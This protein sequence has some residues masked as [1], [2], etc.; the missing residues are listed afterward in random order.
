M[1]AIP[2]VA[3]VVVNW[4]GLADT[5]ECLESVSRITYPDARVIVVDNGSR[6]D[7]AHALRAEF[8]GVEVLEAGANLGFTG[9]NNLGI[10]RALAEGAEYV[11]C[12][13]N[14]TVVDPGFLEPL[15]AA[16]EE[17]AG[18]GAAVSKI[19]TFDTPEQVWYA[20]ADCVLDLE[21]LRARGVPAWH[22]SDEQQNHGTEPF[23]T[24]VATGCAL[25]V[26]ASLMRDLGGFD[27]RYFAYY[28]DVD[29]SLRLEKRSSR[30]LVVPASR[31]WHKE[32]RSTGGKLS[33]TALFYLIRNTDLLA[34]THLE[35]AEGEA[36]YRRYVKITKDR[37]R[38]SFLSGD[39]LLDARRVEAVVF[40][41]WCVNRKHYGRRP[42]KPWVE[43]AIRLGVSAMGPWERLL[44]RTVFRVR[45]YLHSR[46]PSRRSVPHG[47]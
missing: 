23:E 12:L 3:I 7:E 35:G 15:V 47:N 10:G 22:L 20:G 43:T 38:R 21:T 19:Y 4:N 39:D 11:L 16:L 40:A 2:A 29:L 42:R 36:Y 5:R 32:S 31:V 30:R 34:K 13:N 27:D 45:W 1:T 41:L 9:G 37:L 6:E 26:R 24:R 46:L 44:S 28:E 14:D 17:D 33:P 8:P 25:L 18:A